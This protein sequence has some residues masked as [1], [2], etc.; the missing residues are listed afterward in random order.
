[1]SAKNKKPSFLNSLQPNIDA[2][3][4][5]SKHSSAHRIAETQAQRK[6]RIAKA[7]A[8]RQEQNARNTF[9]QLPGTSGGR[10]TRRNTRR[11]RNTRRARK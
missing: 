8:N 10:R 2:A 1:M 3:E 6:A 4:K 5:F 7:E 11:S 9:K